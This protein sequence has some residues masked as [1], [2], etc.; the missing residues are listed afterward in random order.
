MQN[1]IQIRDLKK[2]YAA[3]KKS[4][5]KEA[6]KGIT[7]DIPQGSIYGLLGPNGAGKSTIINIMAGL[8]MKTSGMVQIWDEDLDKRPRNARSA[9][10]IVPQEINFD[11]FFTPRQILDIQAGLYGVPKAERKTEE[12]LEMVELS[13]KA[14]A[15]SR[16]LSGG[17]KRR[18]MV[19]KALV[20]TPPIL[21]LDEPTAGVDVEL[22]KMLWENVKRLN[23][24][25]MTI[26]LTTHYLE[27]AEELCDHIAIINHGE[28]VANEEKETLLARIDNK[29]IRFR[30][31]NEIKEIPDA[32]AKFKAVKEG[33]RTIAMRYSP[34][35]QGMG[36]MLSIIQTMDN[37]ITDISTDDSDLE[38]VFLQITRN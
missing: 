32:L 38:D 29:E 13:D 1:A 35:E 34:N 31:E 23:R 30:F 12:L 8:V 4:P 14:D 17:M 3:Q 36:D 15:H 25:G 33:R 16:S 26:V 9:I 5:A 22:R 37:K 11:P 2:T 10:G 20:H 21:V 28:I 7:L 24:Q 19:A 18:L 6:L 27:E